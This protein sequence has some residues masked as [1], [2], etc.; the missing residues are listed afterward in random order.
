M[1]MSTAM[2]SERVYSQIKCIYQH[3]RIIFFSKTKEMTIGFYAHHYIYV[4]SLLKNIAQ[5]MHDTLPTGL[6]I[7]CQNK[8]W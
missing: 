3:K 5:N 4:N 2:I 8:V 7:Y 6:T 1:K